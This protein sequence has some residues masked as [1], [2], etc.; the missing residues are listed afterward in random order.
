MTKQKYNAVFIS[1]VH[2]GAAACQAS[3]LLK[4]L[5]SVRCNYLFLVGDI[6]DGWKLKRRFLWPDSYSMI[7]RQILTMQKRGTKIIYLTGNHDEFLRS[8]LDHIEMITDTITIVD[9]YEYQSLS[10]K[11]YLVVHGDLFDGVHRLAKWV[12]YLGDRAYSIMIVVNQY[13]NDLRRSMGL[14]YW[15]LSAY[16]KH[17][18]KRAT[19]FIFSFEQNLAQYAETKKCDGVI[20]GHIHTAAIKHIGEIEYM[21]CGDW[22]ESCTALVETLDGEFKIVKVV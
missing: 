10:G 5:K 12:S 4:F 11:K 22:V 17:N 21:N 7:V 20:C 8:W 2:M 1:D 16:L 15:S 3:A 9:E 6:L 13:M 14:D 18:V 19:S